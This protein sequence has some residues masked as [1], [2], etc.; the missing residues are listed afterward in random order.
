MKRTPELYLLRETIM[1]E[2]ES[3]TLTDE[4]GKGSHFL[5]E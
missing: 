4:V 5:A 1:G 2:H 3:G